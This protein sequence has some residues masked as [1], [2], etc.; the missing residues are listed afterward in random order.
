VLPD[1]ECTPVELDVHDGRRPRFQLDAVE[2]G[3]VTER[4]GRITLGGADVHLE[5]LA[6]PAPTG[7]GDPTVTVIP[8]A[9]L[10]ERPAGRI[11]NVV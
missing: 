7:V 6:A 11:E 1:R 3:Q 8:S 10:P 4:T 2:P 9:V 5:D